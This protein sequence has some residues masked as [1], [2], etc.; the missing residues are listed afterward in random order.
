[1]SLYC[2]IDLHANNSYVVVSGQEDEVVLG[3]RLP[4]DL[5]RIEQVL[6]P[7]REALE[8]IAVESTFNWY[9]LVDGLRQAGHTVHLVNPL[10]AQQYQGLKYADDRSDAR[11]LAKML[12]LEILPTGWICPATERGVR[13][14]LRKR[15][16]LVR[17]RVACRLSLRNILE[18]TTARRLTGAALERLSPGQLSDW[19]ADENVRLS[20]TTTLAVIETLDEQIELL[21][22]VVF[23]QARM[24]SAFSVLQTIPGVGPILASTIHY[25]T[26]DLSRFAGVGHYASYCRLVRSQHLSNERRK[27]QGLRKNGNAYLSWAYHEAAHFAVRYQP[28]ARRWHERKRSKTCALVAIRALAHKLARAAYFMMRDQVAYEPRQAG[29]RRPRGFDFLLDG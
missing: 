1:M 28:K 25:E 10:A 4:N 5:D 11:W 26:G 8:G 13:D 16:Q 14:L 18:R 12:R 21:E 24:A 23:E 7:Y 6:E 19:I 15:V 17:Q 27:G 29:R 3:Q 2:G 20:M 22:G 9:W